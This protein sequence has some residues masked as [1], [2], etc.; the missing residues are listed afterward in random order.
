MNPEQRIAELE[1]RL[2]TAEDDARKAKTWAWSALEQ[3][4]ALALSIQRNNSA[5]TDK[6]INHLEKL[7]V[8]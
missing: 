5:E 6:V 7:G 3:I 2:E 8:G 4:H 1:A